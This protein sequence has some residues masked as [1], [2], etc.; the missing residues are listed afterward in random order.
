META[1]TACDN[2]VSNI[3]DFSGPVIFKNA[4]KKLEIKKTGERTIDRQKTKVGERDR[5]R[6]D[7]QDNV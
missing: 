6:L 7:T 3:F 2:E 5:N 1:P 4:E